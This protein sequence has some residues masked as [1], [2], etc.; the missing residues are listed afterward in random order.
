M[1][2]DRSILITGC[3]SGIGRCVAEGLKTRGYRVIASA[4]Q[5]QD[6]EQLA[7]DG[8]EALSLDLDSSDS[9]AEAVDKTLE[10]CGGRLYAIFNNGAYGQP[11][12][13]ED[14]SRETLRRQFETNLFGW[15]EL[16]C[17]VIPPMRQAGEG[18]I[19]QNSSILGF[20]TL[21][22]RG[23]YVASKY[24]LEGLS[25]TLRLEL[26]GSGIHVSLIQ[27]G[28]ILSRF[29]EN[30]LAKW[31]E[32]IDAERSYHRDHYQAMLARLEKEGP[33][34]P[35]TLPPEAVLRKAIHALESPYPKPR[36]AVTLPTYLFAFLRRLLTSRGMDRLLLRVSGS[37]QR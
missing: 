4:R 14:L 31:R 26:A 21:P 19:I 12:A 6:V 17:R 28:P 29:R 30:A 20:M 33:A 35:F 27:P 24:A 10:Y 22:Y 5:P 8:F 15:H 9:I 7:A 32:N 37:G 23:A 25:D 1:T 3:S 36:Y 13:V 34:M 11:G 18:R 2:N 16:T